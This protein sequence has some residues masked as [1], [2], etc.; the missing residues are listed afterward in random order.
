M[1]MDKDEKI[2]RNCLYYEST[3][4]ECRLRTP[5]LVKHKPWPVVEENWWC[6]QGRWK[7]YSEITGTIEE[8][9]REWVDVYSLSEKEKL[10][11]ME[12]EIR[13]KRRMKYGYAD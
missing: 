3:Q 1:S 4:S 9:D 10:K 11:E 13:R 2:C 12:D 7:K 8:Y 6:F 5:S